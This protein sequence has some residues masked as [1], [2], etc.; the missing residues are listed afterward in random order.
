M[1]KESIKKTQTKQLMGGKCTNLKVNYERKLP[2]QN[3][4]DDIERIKNLSRG[5]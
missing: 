1:E 5:V 2:L 3:L 4:R